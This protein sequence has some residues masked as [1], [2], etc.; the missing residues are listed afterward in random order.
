MPALPSLSGLSDVCIDWTV[1]GLGLEKPEAASNHPE[2]KK[3]AATVIKNVILGPT[4]AAITYIASRHFLEVALR[5]IYVGASSLFVIGAWVFTCQN[6]RKTYNNAIERELTVVRTNLDIFWRNNGAAID[7]VV[8]Q[9]KT[10]IGGLHQD[11][12]FEYVKEQLLEINKSVKDLSVVN[13]H[14]MIAATDKKITDLLIELFPTIYPSPLG[15]GMVHVG[16]AAL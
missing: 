11:R 9:T 10:I 16:G 12:R 4:L 15:Q 14:E 8:K 13:S 5:P 1:W 6:M 2:T 3:L 7:E